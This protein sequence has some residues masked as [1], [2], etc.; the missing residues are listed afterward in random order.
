MFSLLRLLMDAL[1]I[2]LSLD[3]LG[4]KVSLRSFICKSFPPKFAVI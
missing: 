4:A 1:A 2:E 3:S